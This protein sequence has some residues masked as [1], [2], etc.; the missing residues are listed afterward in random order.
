MAPRT[1]AYLFFGITLVLAAV[2]IRLGIWQLSRLEERRAANRIALAARRKPALDLD[3][4]KALEGLEP[5]TLGNRRMKLT[6]RYDHAAE[7]VLRSQSKEG[8]AGVRIVTPL[9][10]LRG[11]TA[12]LVQRGFVPSPDA[13]TVDLTG[14]EEMGVV[15]VR[16]VVRLLDE[17]PGEPLDAGG[18][19][20]WRRVDL[21]A[22]RLRLPYPI[23]PFL[24]LQTRDSSLPRLPGRDEPPALDD[25]P[26]LSYAIQWFAFAVTAVVVGGI[27]GFS[28]K[29]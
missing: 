6:G 23:A 1:R 2:F 24:V 5:G 14:L 4:P 18:Q 27:I 26:H 17:V 7:I 13:T 29:G 25:G 15:T 3:D 21:A 20:T 19:L 10:L 11:D 16:G 8:V 9:R 22:L 28:K 12:V